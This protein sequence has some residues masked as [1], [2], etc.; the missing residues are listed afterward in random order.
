MQ[1]EINPNEMAQTSYSNKS[2]LELLD[3]SDEELE[4]HGYT[5]KQ[6]EDYINSHS[7]GNFINGA[8]HAA[9]IDRSDIT[10]SGLSQ[11]YLNN[12]VRALIGLLEP[13]FPMFGREIVIYDQDIID[14]MMKTKTVLSQDE[15]EKELNDYKNRNLSKP[16]ETVQSTNNLSDYTNHSGGAL[17]KE[18]EGDRKLTPKERR[19]SA[20]L[21]W[22]DRGDLS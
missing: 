22:E 18:K 12:G 20:D 11:H 1:F 21:V 4:K 10:F 8:R 13:G 14:S 3:E 16:I 9:D 6:V 17:K 5:R 2:W 15:F 7:F 19:I